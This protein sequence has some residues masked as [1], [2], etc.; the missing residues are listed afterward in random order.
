MCLHQVVPGP[1]A[2]MWMAAMA[3]EIVT[4]VQIHMQLRG[5][6]H[7]ALQ[8]NVSDPSVLV[9]VLIRYGCEP[10]NATP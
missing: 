6:A 8:A 4:L 5:A 2:C 7:E 10:V 9:L 1:E 3:R